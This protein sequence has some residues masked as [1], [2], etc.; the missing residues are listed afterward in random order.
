LNWNA[1]IVSYDLIFAENVIEV[2]YTAP[3]AVVVKL[4]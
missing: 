1:N 2:I 4:K 3:A